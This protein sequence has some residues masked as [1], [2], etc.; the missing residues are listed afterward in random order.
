MSK[1]TGLEWRTDCLSMTEVKFAH[2][3]LEVMGSC[4]YLGD[5]FDPGEECVRKLLLEIELSR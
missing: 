2:I 5:K 3:T 1:I 4:C